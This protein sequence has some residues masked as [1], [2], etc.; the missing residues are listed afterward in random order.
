MAYSSGKFPDARAAY[1]RAALLDP[2]CE[3]C[4]QKQLDIEIKIKAEIDH[5]M[6]AGMDY[7]QTERYEDARRQFEKVKMLDPDPKGIN[8]GNATNKINDIEKKLQEQR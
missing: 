8:Y 3:R 7:F 5:A 2:S 4:K 6:Q 1:A